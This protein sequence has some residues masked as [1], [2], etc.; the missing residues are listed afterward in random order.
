MS[1]VFT[2]MK[3]IFIVLTILAVALQL[4]YG[5]PPISVVANV[6]GKKY[7]I[8]AETVEEFSEQVES[9]AGLGADQQS[10]LFRGKVLNSDDKLEE[11]GVESG[12]VLNVLKGRK[13]RAP[14]P[15]AELDADAD[16]MVDP[17]ADEPGIQL[18]EGG[19]FLCIQ[20]IS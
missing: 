15:T 7:E 8:T 1:I 4:A 9:L 17:L 20:S 19:C 11:L 10:V 6:R 12:D 2:N 14:K 16:S 5:R 18:P 13:P 3:G